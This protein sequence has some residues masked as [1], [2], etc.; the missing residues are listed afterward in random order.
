MEEQKKV[1]NPY[2]PIDWE[3]AD[4]LFEAGCTGREVAAY[5]G[6]CPDTLYIRCQ[7]EKKLDFSAYLALKRAKGDS[8]LRTKQYKVAM[9]GNIAMLV[10]L[11]KQ[12]LEQREPDSKQYDTTQP[13]QIFINDILQNPKEANAD[14][15]APNSNHNQASKPKASQD[16]PVSPAKAP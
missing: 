7:S 2:I 8:S 6:C 10:W 16:N 3:E 5:F 15:N 4:K 14:K 9:D 13:V 12:R 1:S 11:G